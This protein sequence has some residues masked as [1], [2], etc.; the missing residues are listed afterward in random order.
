MLEI[1]SLNPKA[2]EGY[3][4]ERIKH[5]EK[6]FT[7]I[8]NVTILDPDSDSRWKHEFKSDCYQKTIKSLVKK[9]QVHE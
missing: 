6:E 4:K 8:N 7:K 5:Y 3:K 2:I 1:D 9:Y